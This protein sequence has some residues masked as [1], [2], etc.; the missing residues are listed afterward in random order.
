MSGV[1]GRIGDHWGALASAVL[2]IGCNV[3]PVGEVT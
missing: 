1:V 2:V 3:V